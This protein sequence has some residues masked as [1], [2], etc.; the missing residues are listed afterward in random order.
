MRV[1]LEI[2][3]TGEDRARIGRDYLG[4]MKPAPEEGVRVWAQDVITQAL[5][6]LEEGEV[7]D[8]MACAARA[9][10]LEVM[11]PPYMA[12]V[13]NYVSR[14]STGA[15]RERELAALKEADAEAEEHTQDLIRRALAAA[16]A[17]R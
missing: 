7:T 4:T 14:S 1:K 5:K 9:V 11:A 8:R 17:A 10:L 3:V 15:Q 6:R 16:L 12:R 13:A 2:E